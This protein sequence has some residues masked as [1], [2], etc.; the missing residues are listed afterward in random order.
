MRRY[1]PVECLLQTVA[2][3][4]FRFKDLKLKGGVIRKDSFHLIV[5]RNFSIYLKF[6][7]ILTFSEASAAFG[8]HSAHKK[9]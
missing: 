6:A 2:Y 7:F 9:L 1:P 8:L 5:F 4:W 3:S